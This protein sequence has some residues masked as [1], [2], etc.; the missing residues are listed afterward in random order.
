MV[1][2]LVDRMIMNTERRNF[3]AGAGAAATST[4]VLGTK[5]SL[6]EVDQ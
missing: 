4:V 6:A 5:P 2:H 3:V 1:Q